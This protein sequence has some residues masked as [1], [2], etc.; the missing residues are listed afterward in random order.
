MHRTHVL[1][2]A[3]RLLALF[4]AA[5]TLAGCGNLTDVQDTPA[6]ST[7]PTATP[8][9]NVVSLGVAETTLPP[10]PTVTPTPIP[11]ETPIPFSY[12]APTVNMS[13]EEL[14]GSLADVNKEAREVLAA[15]Y[16]APD[17]YYIIVDIYWQVVMV[18]RKGADGK[19]DYDQPVRYMLCSTGNPKVGSETARGIF[20]I[21]KPRVRF[22]QFL[23]GET[24]QYWTLIRSRTYFHSVLYK[25]D[26]DISS[27]DVESYN[28]LGSKASHACIR[29]TV[30]DARWIFYNIGY[31]TICEIRDGSKSD[32]QTQLIRSQLI[33]PAAK[34]GLK[35]KAGEAPWTDNWTIEGVAH[36]LEYKYEAPPRPAEDDDDGDDTPSPGETK[37]PTPSTEDPGTTP[38][39]PDDSQDAPAPVVP[40]EPSGGENEGSSSGG[41]SEGGDAGGSEG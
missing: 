16:P 41:G 37:T 33:L 8:A 14:V 28:N 40:V 20:E 7:A 3:L 35:L 2:S 27:Y 13:F 26:K 30:P 15:G 12:Y 39:P 17:T 36:E 11:E 1:S 29:L 4:L 21:K 10:A 22:G 31:G 5:A 38:E 18:Y 25:K 6:P 24:A 32:S 9:P 19:P 34:T 23:S